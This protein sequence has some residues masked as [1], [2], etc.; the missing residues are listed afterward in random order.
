[1]LDV[2]EMAAMGGSK[3]SHMG[4][5]DMYKSLICLKG[6]VK[7]AL[8]SS[9]PPSNSLVSGFELTALFKGPRLASCFA[10]GTT[11]IQGHHQ[12]CRAGRRGPK[13]PSKTSDTNCFPTILDF[14]KTTE[15]N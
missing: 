4:G 5:V 2:L 6:P 12:V 7:E 13:K 15:N 14:E 1:M 9:V 10:S 8:F 3:Q 11:E